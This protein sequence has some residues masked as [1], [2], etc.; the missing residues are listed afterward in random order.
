MNRSARSGLLLVAAVAMAA[1]VFIALGAS[2]APVQATTWKCQSHWPTASPSYDDSLLVVIKQLKERTGGRLVIEPFAASS[3]MPAKEIFNGVKRGVVECGTTSPAYLRDQISIAGIAA[4]VPYSFKEVWEAVY[5]HK[6]L[7]FE[8]MMYDE[9]LKHGVYYFTE[10]VYP[11]ELVLKKPVNSF[12]DFKGL[13]LRSSGV[14]Q[15]YFTDVGAAASYLPGPEVY[16]ALASGVVDG[17][18]WGAAQGANKM[19]FYDT[20]KYHMK[21]PFNIAGTDAWV[22]NK[23]AVDKLPADVKQI[24]LNTIEQHF[25]MRT[26]QYQLQEATTLAEVQK[27]KGV[28]VITL[29]PADQKK[30]TEAAQKIWDKEAA[31]SPLAAEAISRMK[32]FLK[33]LGHL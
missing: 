21:P 8:K 15:V 10:K 18:H 24:F 20:A 1:L 23:K 32:D 11:T 30:L 22:F 17:A 27:T 33:Q 7:G 14:L 19:G 5:F 16:P 9:A 29:P 3:L 25:W 31:R 28:T 12:A 4:G 6:H 26:N 2:P 13:K